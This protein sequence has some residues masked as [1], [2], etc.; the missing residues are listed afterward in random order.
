MAV[1]CAPTL[2]RRSGLPRPPQSGSRAGRQWPWPDGL[3]R[4]ADDWASGS[5][6]PTAARPPRA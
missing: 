4:D 6:A 5:R 2:F 1:L 3:S